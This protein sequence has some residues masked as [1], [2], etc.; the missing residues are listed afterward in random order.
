MLFSAV[1]FQGVSMYLVRRYIMI[2][3]S[4]VENL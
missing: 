1:A 4:P 3:L 2:L